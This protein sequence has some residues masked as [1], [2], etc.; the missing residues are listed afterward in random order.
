MAGRI[1]DEDV[2]LVKERAD[3]AEVIGDHVTLRPG[4]GGSLKGLCPFHDEKSP[5][6][7]VRPSVGSFHCFGCQ[8]SGDV[9][10]FV[11]KTDHLT[12]AESVERLAARYNVQLRYEEGGFTPNRQQG[13]RQRLVEAHKAAAEFYRERLAG[14]DAEVGR[15]FLTE[16]GFDEAA[17]AHFGVGFAPQG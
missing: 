4:G 11:M 16:R 17:A 15:Q 14:P 3:L 2:V 1:R 7:S 9:I 5:S 10:S 12:F 13:Q 8:E 6:F